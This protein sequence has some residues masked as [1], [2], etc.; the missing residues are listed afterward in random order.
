MWLANEYKAYN[1]KQ[2]CE[3]YLE[4]KLSSQNVTWCFELSLKHSMDDLKSKCVQFMV[5]ND[6]ESMTSKA[7]LDIDQPTL[8]AILQLRIWESNKSLVDACFRWAKEYCKKNQLNPDNPHDLRG[9]LGNAF[10]FIPFCAMKPM[11]FFGFHRNY[12]AM[13]S[14]SE[15]RKVYDDLAARS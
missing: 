10:Q 5:T 15:I 12:G 6:K 13:F 9:A 1:V 7:F 2:F 4:E 8:K 3:D 11:E 14:D